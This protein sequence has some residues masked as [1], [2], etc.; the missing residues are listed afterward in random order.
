MMD[1][2]GLPKQQRGVQQPDWVYKRREYLKSLSVAKMNSFHRAHYSS[3]EG[4]VIMIEGGKNGGRRGGL[5]EKTRGTTLSHNI[6]YVQYLNHMI[7]S[8]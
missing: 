5:K 8:V 1:A 6:L 4:W 2:Y 3:L 7:F